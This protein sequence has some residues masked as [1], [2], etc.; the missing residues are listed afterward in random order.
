MLNS[1]MPAPERHD[2][3]LGL[4]GDCNLKGELADQAVAQLQPKNVRNTHED[5]Q[6]KTTPKGRSGDVCS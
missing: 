4:L 1:S 5:W 2:P 6:V 3:V